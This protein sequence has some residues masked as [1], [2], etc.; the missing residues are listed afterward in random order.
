MGVRTGDQSL[1]VHDEARA[2]LH[3]GCFGLRWTAA[4]RPFLRDTDRFDSRVSDMVTPRPWRA[5]T[6]PLATPVVLG[7]GRLRV[8]SPGKPSRFHGLDGLGN[9]RGCLGLGRAIR[10]RRLVGQLAGVDD[11]KADVRPVEAPVRVRHGHTADAAWPM[12]A[13]RRLLTGPPR[14]F[15]PSG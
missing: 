3:L 14:F 6:P 13:A 11:Q 12:P 1:W 8:S 9:T 4:P 7:D 2:H 15:E 10:R 5:P